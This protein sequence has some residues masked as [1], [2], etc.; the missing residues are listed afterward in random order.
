MTLMSLWAAITRAIRRR[1]RRLLTAV[2]RTDG[3]E[4]LV[5]A[6][7]KPVLRDDW[8][9]GFDYVCGHCKKMVIAS[10]VTGGQIW[11]LAFQCFRCKGIS[12]SPVLPLQLLPPSPPPPPPRRLL[13]TRRRPRGR[14]QE[15]G[16]PFGH[17]A[18]LLRHVVESSAP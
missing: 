8:P 4:L 10:C 14:H 3:I 7:R 9:D 11:D 6:S 17:G 15:R 12:L 5:Q 18:Q 1:E 16:Q 2:Q 13:P